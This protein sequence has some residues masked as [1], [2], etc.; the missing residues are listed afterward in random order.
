[1]AM[2]GKAP[3]HYEARA[4]IAR[5]LAHPTRLLLLDVLKRKE[6]CVCDLTDIAGV[7]Q[8]TVS[9][10]LAILREAGLV[11]SRKEGTMTFYRQTATCLEGFFACVE[12]ILKENLA[13][14]R[15]V[16]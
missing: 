7:D 1:M 6:T 4:K 5:A 9:K 14:Q 12:T 8:S 10:H 15:A 11:A 3:A 2:K 16:L 13:A